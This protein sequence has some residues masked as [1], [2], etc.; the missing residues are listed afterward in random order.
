MIWILLVIFLLLLLLILPVRIDVR[1]GIRCN[2]IKINVNLRVMSILPISLEWRLAFEPKRG[3]V[4]RVRDRKGFRIVQTLG[5]PGKKK[6]EKLEKAILYAVSKSVHGNEIEICGEIGIKDNPAAG[7]ITAG[8]VEIKLN[9]ALEFLTSLIFRKKCKILVG[10]YPNLTQNA[11][12]LNLEGIFYAI[13]VKLLIE[14]IAHE[15]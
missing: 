1:L 9:N 4:V 5:D 13:P 12:S 3:F 6:N 10:I 14:A 11:F 15:N 2:Y 7:V 8:S